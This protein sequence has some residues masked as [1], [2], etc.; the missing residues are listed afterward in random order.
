MTVQ[1]NNR[2][3]GKTVMV[4]PASCPH[5]L[6]VTMGNCRKKIKV[7]DIPLGGGGGGGGGRRGG[8]GHK[9][10]VH[11]GEINYAHQSFV[12][13][14]RV[15]EQ[16]VQVHTR[17]LQPENRSPRRSPALWA[18][19]TNDLCIRR[20]RAQLNDGCDSRKHIWWKASSLFFKYYYLL[21][22]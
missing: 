1:Y 7:L 3:L 16:L 17:D 13:T 8:S 20:C 2:L 11:K 22:L 9:W 18:V 6:L 15:N 12:T 4:L 14:P 10:L 5:S 19:V 21:H